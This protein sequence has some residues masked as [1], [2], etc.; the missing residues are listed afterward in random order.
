MSADFHPGQ[1]VACVNLRLLD[2]CHNQ[3]LDRLLLGQVY[4][5]RDIE[6]YGRCTTLGLRIEGIVLP[7]NPSSLREWTYD[8]RRFRP[9]KPTNIEMLRQICEQVREGQRQFEEMIR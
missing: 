4:T 6:D 7:I 9:C 1:S 8:C 2:G 3:F 5:V